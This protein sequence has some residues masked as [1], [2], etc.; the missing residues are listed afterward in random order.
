MYN[1]M[2]SQTEC[3]EGKMTTKENPRAGAAKAVGYGD[4]QYNGAR[5]KSGIRDAGCADHPVTYFDGGRK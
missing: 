1:G 2:C 4:D 5:V 3:G